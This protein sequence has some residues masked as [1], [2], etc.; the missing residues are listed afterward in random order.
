MTST[1][2]GRVHQVTGATRGAGR[3]IAV[4]LGTPQFLE[5]VRPGPHLAPADPEPSEVESLRHRAAET[6][7]LS[8]SR[9]GVARMRAPKNVAP[10]WCSADIGIPRSHR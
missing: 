2:T 5:T 7:A 8:E 3:G 1:L 10:P 6:T 4:E 9:V